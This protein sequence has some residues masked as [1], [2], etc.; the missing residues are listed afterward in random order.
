MHKQRKKKKK[1]NSTWNSSNGTKLDDLSKKVFVT[2]CPLKWTRI[3]PEI[4]YKMTV[5]LMTVFSVTNMAQNITE[6]ESEITVSYYCTVS[7]CFF[8]VCFTLLYTIP[9]I[10]KCFRRSNY[11]VTTKNQQLLNQLISCVGGGALLGLALLD[12]MPE[13][14]ERIEEETD[15]SG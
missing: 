14:R 4:K 11:T 1:E 6:L 15:V 7:L 13:L 2:N 3:S 10:S 12:V 9:T 5:I 8:L